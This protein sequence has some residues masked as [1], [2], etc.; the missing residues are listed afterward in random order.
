LARYS[1]TGIGGRDATILASMD[2]LGIKK[3]MTHDRAF[4]RIDQ[5]EVVDPVM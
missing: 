5:I 2:M 3:L 1:Q 4:K